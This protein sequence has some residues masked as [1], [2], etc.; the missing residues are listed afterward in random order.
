MARPRTI[1]VK[2]RKFRVVIKDAGCD[3]NGHK[4]DGYV[5]RCNTIVVD[6]NLPVAAQRSTLIHETLHA[7]YPFLTEREVL[8]G[9]QTLFELLKPYLK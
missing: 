6:K 2:G 7:L 1:A 8:E 4:L 5:T 9:E 3:E